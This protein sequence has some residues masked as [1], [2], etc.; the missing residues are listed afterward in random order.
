MD[1]ISYR[2]PRPVASHSNVLGTHGKVFSRLAANHPAFEGVAFNSSRSVCDCYLL[3]GLVIL[4]RRN[5]WGVRRH[6]SRIGIGNIQFGNFPEVRKIFSAG[7]ESVSRRRVVPRHGHNMRIR[8]S[9]IVLQLIFHLADLH[10]PVGELIFGCIGFLS[11]GNSSGEDLI[12][13]G[14]NIEPS[15]SGSVVCEMTRCRIVVFIFNHVFD[16]NLLLGKLSF[17][18]ES[19]TVCCIIGNGNRVILS[20]ELP[21]VKCIAG[22]TR[23]RRQRYGVSR[24]RG[25]VRRQRIPL[26]HSRVRGQDIFDGDISGRRRTFLVEFDNCVSVCRG[27]NLEIP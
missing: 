27:F 3:A 10:R 7:E 25:Y 6:C 2:V 16:M 8:R 20:V 13:V 14:H 4:C 17:D 1:R 22:Y 11:F 23:L 19:L 9:R 15:M 21:A 26:R 5:I 24:M 12:H 18:F